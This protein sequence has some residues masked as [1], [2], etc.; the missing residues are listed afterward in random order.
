MRLFVECLLCVYCNKLLFIR[1]YFNVFL[2]KIILIIN[3]IFFINKLY[4]FRIGGE[5]CYILKWVLY[6]NLIIRVME[7]KC[8]FE[9]Y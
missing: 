2:K 3:Y 4:F 9:V 1:F 8:I 5:M 6:E 7:I